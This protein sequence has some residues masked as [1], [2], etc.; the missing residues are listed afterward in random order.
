[1][2]IDDIIRRIH[3][4][5]WLMVLVAAGGG[6]QAMADLLKV[7]GASRTVLE[8]RVPYSLASLRDLLGGPPEQACSEAT[9]RAM[10]MAAFLRARELYLAEHP[11]SGNNVPVVGVSCTASLA[12]DRPKKGPHRIH[13][14]IQ[15]VEFTRSYSLVLNKGARSRGEEEEV[16]RRLFLQGIATACDVPFNEEIPLLAGESIEHRQAE[17]PPAWR[18]L[19]LGEADAVSVGVPHDWEKGRP[20]LIFPGAFNP[21]HEGHLRMARLAEARLGR[22]VEFEISILN[23]DKPP[24]DYVE[25]K[26][27]VEQFSLQERVWLTRLPTFL[28]KARR[29]PGCT[30]VVGIDTLLRIAD[31]RYYRHEPGLRDRA[32]AE[33]SQL[34]CRFLVFGRVVQGRFVTLEDIDIPP[35]LRALCEGVRESEFRHDI[36]STEIRR[37]GQNPPQ[38]PAV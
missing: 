9:A 14:A 36:S 29:F 32:I 21:L 20:P 30:F 11:E 12:T 38:I 22:P 6:S 26:D 18:S 13:V 8:A 16:A 23:V 15:R 2:A 3:E 5:P 27:R 37:T 25:M 28:E 17:A 35:Q 33:M 1:M 10:A 24:L 4:T 19:L 31:P 7:P 34:G